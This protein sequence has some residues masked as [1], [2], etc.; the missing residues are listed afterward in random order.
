MFNITYNQSKHRVYFRYGTREVNTKTGRHTVKTTTATLAKVVGQ[1][2]NKED[3]LEA[4]FSETVGLHKG[5]QDI[6]DVA[7]KT[8]L[9]RVLKKLPRHERK[10]FWDAYF[11]KQNKSFKERHVKQG[12]R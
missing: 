11:D 4:V 7:R 1:K 8:A 2:A 10:Q 9:S 12:V 3:I 5:D 6:R